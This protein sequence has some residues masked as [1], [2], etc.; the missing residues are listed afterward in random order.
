MIPVVFINSRSVPFVDLIME[1]KKQYETR[2]RDVLRFLSDSGRRFL[3]A[4]TGSGRP[5]VRCS[6]RIRSVVVIHSEKM[7]NQYRTCHAVPAGSAYDW[8]PCTNKKILYELADVQPVPVPFHPPE[9]KRHGRTWME[10]N[11][12][13]SL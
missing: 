12:V 8:K 5:L 10:C 4:E 6:A 1:G 2:S 11:L 3:I 13:S 9:G 7:W